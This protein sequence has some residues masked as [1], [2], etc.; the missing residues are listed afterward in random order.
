MT[1]TQERSRSRKLDLKPE[2]RE[3]RRLGASEPTCRLEVEAWPLFRIQMK[4]RLVA[5]SARLEGLPTGFLDLTFPFPVSSRTGVRTLIRTGEE[6][7]WLTE[8]RLYVLT[9]LSC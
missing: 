6:C 7:R 3:V 5:V 1:L 4:T 8:R 9:G 2:F